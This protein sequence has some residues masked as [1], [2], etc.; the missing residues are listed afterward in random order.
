MAIAITSRQLNEAEPVAMRIEP[1]GLGIDGDAV[2]E[3]KAVWEVTF[4]QFDR[5][6][7]PFTLGKGCNWC[8]GEGHDTVYN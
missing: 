7:T 5:Q 1:H 3:V 2:A 8:P 6:F 4:I